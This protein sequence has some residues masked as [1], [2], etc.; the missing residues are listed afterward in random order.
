MMEVKVRVALRLLTKQAHT[1]LLS[2]DQVIIDS[3]GTSGKIVGEIVEEEYPDARPA[4][5]D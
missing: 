5:A 3:S 4:Y 1:G 2:L